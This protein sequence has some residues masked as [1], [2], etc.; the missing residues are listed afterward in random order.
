MSPERARACVVVFGREPRPGQVKSRLADGIGERPAARV[1]E[2]LLRHTLDAAL[3]TG[4][5]VCLALSDEPSADFAWPAGIDGVIQRGADLGERMEGC[6]E[7]RFAA[8][9]ER[10]V[11]VGTDIPGLRAAHLLA[12]RGRLTAVPVVLGPADDGGYYL[13]AQ[14]APGAS[15]FRDVPWSSPDTLAATRRRIEPLGLFHR[16]LDPLY[17]IDTAEDLARA[18]ADEALPAPLRDALREAWEADLP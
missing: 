1:A 7:D 6:F 3:R 12:A 11:L 18:V 9:F 4:L 2:V 13:V 10:V 5:P 8:G 16:E 14:R 17:D 15:L